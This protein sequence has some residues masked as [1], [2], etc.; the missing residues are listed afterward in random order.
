MGRS[1]RQSTRPISTVVPQPSETELQNLRAACNLGTDESRDEAITAFYQSAVHLVSTFINRDIRGERVVESWP[2]FETIHL[3]ELFDEEPSGNVV[4]SWRDGNH[5]LQ[6]RTLSGTPTSDAPTTNDWLYDSEAVA[7]RFIGTTTPNLS[8]RYVNPISIAYDK[9][10]LLT[11]ER[12][13]QALRNHVRLAY[14]KFYGLETP[15]GALIGLTRDL[16]CPLVNPVI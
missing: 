16:L 11:D 7:F 4:L 15:T 10:A 8:S 14:S 2:R 5:A 9:P 6:Q 13:V 12:I 1:L 3:L